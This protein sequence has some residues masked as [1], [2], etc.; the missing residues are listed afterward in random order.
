[1]KYKK[2]EFSGQVLFKLSNKKDVNKKH[3]FQQF[4]KFLNRTVS[5]YS[6]VEFAR[7]WCYS[8]VVVGASVVVLYARV[9][10]TAFIILGVLFA[11]VTDH[12]ISNSENATEDKYAIVAA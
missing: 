11:A 4:R 12:I 1:M 5:S 7:G 10:L 8:G 6:T 2:D 3:N 9:A